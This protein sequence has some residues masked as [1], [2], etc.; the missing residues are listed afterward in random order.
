[1][2][3][4][5][6]SKYNSFSLRIMNQE[7][8]GKGMKRRETGE[9]MSKVVRKFLRET[10]VFDS[11]CQKLNCRPDA[12]HWCRLVKNIGGANPNIGGNVVKIDKCIGESQI[13]GS[14]HPAAPQ[15]LRL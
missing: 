13:L 7:L 3:V 11:P 2:K 9:F 5:M 10:W 8:V 14:A 1:M 4:H 15:S 12:G 6:N